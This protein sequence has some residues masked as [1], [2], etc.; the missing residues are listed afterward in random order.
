MTTLDPFEAFLAGLV[1]YK[2]MYRV[3]AKQ[4]M[5]QPRG[6]AADPWGVH[7]D[8]AMAEALVAKHTG[9]YWHAVSANFKD[10]PDAGDLEV[11]HTRYANGAILLHETDK[12]DRK[13]VL[14]AGLWPNMR[15]V[16]WIWGR[17]AKQQK[18]WKDGIDRPC[19]WVEQS[20]LNSN[21][22]L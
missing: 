12:D 16:G 15:I 7:I 10:M 4:W 17:D 1:G 8:G 19:F 5:N 14:V 9:K 6:H 13:Y 18:Y 22:S 21:E 11:R 2:R 20:E 3:R